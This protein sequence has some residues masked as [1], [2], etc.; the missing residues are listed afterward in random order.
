MI[1]GEKKILLR[2]GEF[3]IHQTTPNN[4]LQARENKHSCFPTA[5]RDG[6]HSSDCNI[7]PLISLWDGR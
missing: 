3:K 2:S 4:N 1:L 6:G 7:A 5:A